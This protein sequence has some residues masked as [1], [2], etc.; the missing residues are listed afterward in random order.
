M[1]T[2]YDYTFAHLL[3]KSLIDGSLV[4]DSA[5]MVMHGYPSTLSATTELMRLHTE[6]VSRGAMGKFVIADMPFLSFRKGMTFALD[7]ASALM[8]AG[9]PAVKLEGAAR[10]FVDDR[11]L[12]LDMGAVGAA[13]L[14]LESIHAELGEVIGGTKPAAKTKSRRWFG[15]S[16]PRRWMACLHLGG[17]ATTRTRARLLA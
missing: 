8:V 1:V 4:G 16:G 13:G 5:A 2:C 6:A 11:R 17:L 14:G 15:I 9:A 10:V 7:S 12:A 3:S